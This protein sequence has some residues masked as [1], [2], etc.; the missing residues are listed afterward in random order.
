MNGPSR[1]NDRVRG[2]VIR[3]GPAGV[4]LVGCPERHVVPIP[5][6]ESR[7][8][9]ELVQDRVD[10]L[11]LADQPVTDEGQAGEREVELERVRQLLGSFVPG[12]HVLRL[13]D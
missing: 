13:S 4:S 2:L 1:C 10:R 3:S 12:V 8:P 7:E 9:L 11:S 6:W 5:A